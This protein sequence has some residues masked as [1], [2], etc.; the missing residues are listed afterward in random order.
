MQQ[1]LCSQASKE[2][3]GCWS[4]P[5]SSSGWGKP[6]NLQARFTAA[7]LAD[8]DRRA[9]SI[10]LVVWVGTIGAVLG[11][12]AALWANGVGVDMGM[13][14]WSAPSALGI[15]FY[16]LAALV[17]VKWLRPDPLELAGGVD[18]KA[19]RSS[20][21]GDI[22]E[23]WRA[24]WPNTMARL[25]LV[26]MAVSHMAMVAV[27]TMTPLH[28]RDFGDADLSTLVI[29]IHVL[30]MFGLSPV[31]GR[32]AD[33]F[34]RVQILLLGASILGVGTMSAVIAGYVPGLMFVGLFLLGVGWNF[35]LIAGSALLTESLPLS[36]RVG[37]QGFADLSMSVLGATAA[38]GSGLVKANFGYD[39]LAYFA[40]LAALLMVLAAARRLT[41]SV[42]R[43]G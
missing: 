6:S 15:G 35:A 9:R 16:A 12:T 31:I 32:W 3:S 8:E 10:A 23:T 39:Y 42:S 19:E 43:V 13:A 17:V 28:M 21:I 7:D 18:R 29:S 34:G 4:S 33:R 22:G 38:L 24:I 37:A 36:A 26:T 40:S 14:D 27:M 25:A 11:P 5:W 30:G 20:P 41:P 1:V 2:S